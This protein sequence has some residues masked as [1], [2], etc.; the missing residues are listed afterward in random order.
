MQHFPQQFRTFEIYLN[1]DGT[2]SVITINVDPEVA[3]DIP[4]IMEVMNKLA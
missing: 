2:V 3:D 4:A 1:S